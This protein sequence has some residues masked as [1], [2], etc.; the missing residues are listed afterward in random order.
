MGFSFISGAEKVHVYIS[1]GLLCFSNWPI[2]LE[3]GIIP[4]YR[5]GFLDP[6]RVSDSLEMQAQHSNCFGVDCISCASYDT[7]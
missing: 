5:L 2:S 1:L 7:F 3:F 6:H 4:A